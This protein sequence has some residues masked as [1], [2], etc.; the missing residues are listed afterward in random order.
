MTLRKTFTV[1]FVLLVAGCVPSLH[2][3][4]TDKTLV[5]D[6]EIVGKYGESKNLW[7]FVGDPNDKSYDLTIF[8]NSNKKSKLK[9]HLVEFGGHRFFDFY[10]SGDAELEGG[11]WL[12]MHIIPVHVF[13]KVE[14]RE[15]DLMIAAIDFDEIEKLLKEKPALVKYEVLENNRLVLTDTPENLQ[16]FLLEG[17]K[18]KG[19]FGDA[20]K[21]ERVK[22][23]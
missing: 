22:E 5:Y 11:D 6:P 18:I 20:E 2:Q 7:E 15:S 17:M 16:K 13:Y 23:K 4:Y 21:L 3:L 14:Q 8:D 12:V 10:P 9:V 1:L 19:F